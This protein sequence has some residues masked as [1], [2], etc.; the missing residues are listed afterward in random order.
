[1]LAKRRC[2][3]R[4]QPARRPRRSTPARPLVRLTPRAA[5]SLGRQPKTATKKAYKTIGKDG[6]KLSKYNIF[7]QVEVRKLRAEDSSLTYQDARQVGQPCR[8]FQFQSTW[9]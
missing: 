6:K 8:P 5:R 4:P 7:M 3:A 1:M 9:C 2:P